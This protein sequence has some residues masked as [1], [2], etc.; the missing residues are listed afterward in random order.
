MSH[1]SAYHDGYR[2]AIEDVSGLVTELDA[3]LPADLA[4]LLDEL[5]RRMER[6]RSLSRSAL[7]A[8]ATGHRGY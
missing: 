5:T 4:P 7:A 2:Q 3:R 6:A 1:E 8:G